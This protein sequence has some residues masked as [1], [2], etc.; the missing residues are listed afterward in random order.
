MVRPTLKTVRAWGE[1]EV[2]GTQRIGERLADG[3]PEWTVA[4]PCAWQ[5]G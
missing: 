4:G 2:I 1:P 5:K 3:S